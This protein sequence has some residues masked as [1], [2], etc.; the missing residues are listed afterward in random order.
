M[1]IVSYFQIKSANPLQSEVI[2]TLKL[3]NETNANNPEL[4]Q[5][6]RQLDLLARQAYFIRHDRLKSGL[7]ILLFM[8]AIF[9]I[10]ARGYYADQKDIPEKNIDPIDEWALKTKSRKY[11]LWG[12]IV[13]AAIA[14]IFVILIS[15]LLNNEKPIQTEMSENKHDTEYISDEENISPTLSHQEYEESPA[16]VTKEASELEIQETV[17]SI[18]P[19]VINKQ[20]ISNVTFNSFRGNNSNGISSA[21]NVPEKWDLIKG[22]NISWK[23]TVPRKGYNSPI[24]NGNRVFFT[25]ADEQIRELY[26]FDLVTG[27]KLWTL[28]ATN[29]SG[30]P[31]QPPKTTDDTGLAASS[32]ATNGKQVCAIFGTGDIICADMDGKLLWAKNLG[33]PDNHYG[34]SSSLLMHGNTLFVQYDNHESPRLIALDVLTGAERWNK[35]R[36]ERVTWSS[37]IIA[38]INNSPQLVLMG[39]PSISAYNPNNGEQLWRVEGLSGEVAASACYSNGTVFGASEYSNLIAIDAATGNTLWKSDEFLPEVSS[40]VATKDNVYIATVY[41]VVASYNTQTGDLRKTHELKTEFF[42]SPIIVE[43]KIYLICN[44]GKVFIFS[45]DDEFKLLDSFDTGEK[46]FATPAFTDGKIVVRTEKSIYCVGVE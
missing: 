6:I 39:N 42:S 38:N 11:A 25:G 20:I 16:V 24:I 34:Y 27:E 23:K 46:T 12:I 2:E 19:E 40:P 18:T 41:G 35:S 37:P 33:V 30:S 17:S 9:L 22:T 5:Q 31:S 26:C 44:E 7:Y 36:K 29:I 10:C 43:G 4:Q 21:K 8:L 3:I 15:P 14:I 28:A 32:P 13:V 45:A 1:L